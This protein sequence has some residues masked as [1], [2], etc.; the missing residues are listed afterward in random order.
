MDRNVYWFVGFIAIMSVLFMSGCTPQ[1]ADESFVK[2]RLDSPF[3][4]KMN[5][6]GFI[7]SENI[8]II[9][10][11]VTEDSRC[12]IGVRCVW[13]GQASILVA[14]YKNDANLGDFNLTESKN[15]VNF[16]DYSIKLLKL[17]PYPS[18]TQK[19]SD[20]TITLVVSH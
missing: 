16:S 10:L 20:N 12:P 15:E 7:E 18:I 13:A 8:K 11:K 1:V 14:I 9:F 2:A 6:T 3:R 19:I 4:L 17:E 5:Q